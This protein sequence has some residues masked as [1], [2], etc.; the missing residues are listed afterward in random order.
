MQMVELL[1]GFGPTSRTTWVGAIFPE[2][3]AKEMGTGPGAANAVAGEAFIGLYDAQNRGRGFELFD[4]TDY[5]AVGASGFG[6]NRPILRL[7]RAVPRST[8]YRLEII[9]NRLGRVDVLSLG[10][11]CSGA[12]M[13][14]VPVLKGLLLHGVP[15]AGANVIGWSGCDAT[16]GDYCFLRMTGPRVVDVA[17]Q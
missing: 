13:Y 8:M 9:A 2:S 10:E 15:D 4:F 6:T 1:N 5:T 11:Q 7:Q 16:Y 3:T 17:F 12:C 14:R